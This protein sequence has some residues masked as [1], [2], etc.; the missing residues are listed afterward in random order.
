MRD[1]SDF[2]QDMILK[3]LK[4]LQIRLGQ[5]SYLDQNHQLD[6]IHAYSLS[7][8]PFVH[9]LFPTAMPKHKA[10]NSMAPSRG[11]NQAWARR[12]VACKCFQISLSLAGDGACVG[13]GID[14]RPDSDLWPKWS[15]RKMMGVSWDHEC[16]M[17]WWEEITKKS[18]ELFWF[19]YDLV[20]LQYATI[21]LEFLT[22]ARKQLVSWSSE[23]KI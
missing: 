4:V 21:L 16:F 12:A 6:M 23:M 22:V 17:G 3:C 19:G 1:S 2:P 15:C 11:A 10:W 8:F 18:W 7:I 5:I 14:L 13:S 9:D 20:Q